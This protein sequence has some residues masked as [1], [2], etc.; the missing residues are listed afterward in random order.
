MFSHPVDA[1]APAELNIGFIQHDHKRQVEHAPQVLLGQELPIG[2]V[3]GGQEEHFEV[4]VAGTK[5]LYRPDVDLKSGVPWELDHLHI[6]GGTVELVHTKGGRAIDDLPNAG[7]IPPRAK[8]AQD[9]VDQFVGA[10]AHQNGL[11]GH[12]DIL[13]DGLTQPPADGVGIAMII[14]IGA[15]SVQGAL[16]RTIGILVGIQFDEL[17]NWHTQPLG[18]GLRWLGSVFLQ[19]LHAATDEIDNAK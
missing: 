19:A 3:G 11:R 15:Q 1:T 18:D 13:A 6:V 12:V 10:I 2:I 9:E 4:G 14:A 5:I 16:R 7:A 8:E 17:S